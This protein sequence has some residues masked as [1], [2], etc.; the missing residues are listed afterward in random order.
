MKFDSLEVLP[1]EKSQIFNKLYG[2]K[3]IYYDV[4]EAALL[5]FKA[6]VIKH[7]KKNSID[8]NLYNIIKN[9][10]LGLLKQDRYV[11]GK[12]DL[13]YHYP[14]LGLH[15]GKA[16]IICIEKSFIRDERI[17]PLSISND[18]KEMKYFLSNYIEQLSNPVNST[19]GPKYNSINSNFYNYVSSEHNRLLLGDLLNNFNEEDAKTICTLYWLI[20][21]SNQG[22]FQKEISKIFSLIKQKCYDFD[23][24]QIAIIYHMHINCISFGFNTGSI[25][26]INFKNNR[27]VS[28]ENL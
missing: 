14:V 5:F 17:L 3:L 10:F 9:N 19:L 15:S 28:I 8:E 16:F 23:G 13:D 25:I 12:L 21:I 18:Y 1:C 4:C 24:K 2:H 11:V 7:S 22:Y 26:T 20:Y 6:E 27:V